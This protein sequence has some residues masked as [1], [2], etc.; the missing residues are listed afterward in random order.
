MAFVYVLHYVMVEPHFAVNIVR[1]RCGEHI[2]YRIMT[3]A[4]GIQPVPEA[5]VVSSTVDVKVDVKVDVDGGRSI[6]KISV[7]NIR[8]N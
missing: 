1:G 8:N 3:I 7:M 5:A 4:D 2:G 6:Y